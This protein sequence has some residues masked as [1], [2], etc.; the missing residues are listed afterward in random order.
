MNCA[1]VA[2]VLGISSPSNPL[3]GDIIHGAEY[4]VL[5]AVNGDRW[6]EEDETLND[7]LETVPRRPCRAC[8]DE[9][10]IDVED[11]LEFETPGSD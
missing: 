2:V 9:M 3:A 11:C 10:P 7:R 8:V 6:T 1:L 5:R 4:Y